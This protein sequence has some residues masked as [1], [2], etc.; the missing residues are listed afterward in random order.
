[1]ENQTPP[2]LPGAPQPLNPYAAPQA[3]VADFAPDGTL[4][5]AG[6]GMRLAGAIIDTI[7][8]LLLIVPVMFASGYIQ[9]VMRGQQ[10]G[11]GWS[12]GLGLVGFVVFLLING[13]FLHQS[14]Q[15]V[16]KKMLGMRIVDLNGDKPE[17]LRMIGLR[18]AL[19]HLIQLVP[20][21]GSV[22]GLVDVLFIFRED[23]RC[24][25]DL[26]AGTRVVLV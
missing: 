9:M 6:R 17:F 2:P 11:F 18:Y 13:Y 4:E 15:T 21:A 7:L 12:V 1:M 23:R 22:F 10:P 5:L 24:I 16:A 3:V 26:I 14:G 20:I 8:M 19:M 25:H